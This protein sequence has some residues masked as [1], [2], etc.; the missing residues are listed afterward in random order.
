LT[1]ERAKIAPRTTADTFNVL[2]CMKL[3]SL[4]A[5]RGARREKT[6]L[7]GARNLQQKYR[8]HKFFFADR[9][10]GGLFVQKISEK[11]EENRRDIDKFR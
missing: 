10:D 8:N 3:D 7:K 2:N 5:E 9:T 6:N 4:R 1:A 11:T